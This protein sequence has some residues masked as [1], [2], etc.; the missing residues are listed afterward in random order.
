MKQRLAF[1]VAFA[2]IGSLIIG[3]SFAATKAGTACKSLG[4]KRTVSDKKFTCIKSGKKLI[5][6]KGAI[7]NKSTPT[8]ILSF[9][10]SGNDVLLPI[11]DCRLADSSGDNNHLGFPITPIIKDLS[12]IRVFAIPFEFSDSDNYRFSKAQNET[13]FTSVSKY[14]LQES[15]GKT[16]LEFTFPP[17]KSGSAEIQAVTF[18]VDFKDS[19]FKDRFR[20]R[21]VSIS[22]VLKDLLSQT[23]LSWNLG[24]YDGVV[25]YS[26]DSRTFGK[27]GG[28]AWRV[29]ENSRKMQ[30]TLFDSPSG[31]IRSLVFANGIPSVLTHELGHSLFGF[32]DLYDQNSG[33]SFAQGWGI[34]SGPDKGE[35]NL[36]G[37]EKWLT[38]WISPDEI[39]CTK[40]DSTHFLKFVTMQSNSPKLLIYPLDNQRTVV[41]EAINRNVF[42]ITDR[43]FLFSCGKGADCNPSIN[44]GLLAY[45]VDVSKMGQEGSIVVPEI[46]KFPNVLLE[47]SEVAVSGV[48][49]KNLG[50]DKQG[51]FV[52]IRQ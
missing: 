28:I 44:S 31:K 32:I 18:G 12:Q 23:K 34:M 37:W 29:S 20:F 42:S 3:P 4:S 13:M 50:C 2:L 48:S 14:Y 16:N 47:N 41:V 17:T 9:P 26:Q 40:T 6:D 7:V 43:G 30:Q 39:R 10:V 24:S 36:R 11:S 8:P 52:S 15:Y 35:W 46:L 21:D 5:W 1:V 22:S 38:G 27:F 45:T 49:I 51:C 25:L 33:P 19:Q